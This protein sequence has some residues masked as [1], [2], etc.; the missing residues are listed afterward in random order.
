MRR[1]YQVGEALPEDLRQTLALEGDALFVGA[2]FE[3]SAGLGPSAASY[4]NGNR[5]TGALYVFDSFR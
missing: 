2:P 5:D 3:D 1:A 4:D